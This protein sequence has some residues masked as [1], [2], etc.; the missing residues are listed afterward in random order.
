M[1]ILRE[2]KFSVISNC[3][4]K[5]EYVHMKHSGV[6]FSFSMTEL[7]LIRNFVIFYMSLCP[8]NFFLVCATYM[9]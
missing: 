9:A 6:F 8:S 7:A 4:H 2:N 5:R 1:I 3:L